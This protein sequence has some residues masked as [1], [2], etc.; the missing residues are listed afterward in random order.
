LQQRVSHKE[1]QWRRPHAPVDPAYFG[2]YLNENYVELF[3]A[4]GLGVREAYRIACNSFEASFVD[5]TTQ[6]G[7][8]RQLKSYFEGLREHD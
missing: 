4:L 3:S 1:Q 7:W 2:G 8:E 6:R 5:E